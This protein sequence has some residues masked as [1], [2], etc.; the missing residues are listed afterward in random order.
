[1][2]GAGIMK[3]IHKIIAGNSN[4]MDN[5]P[6][7]S[8]DLV[9]TSPPYPMIKMWD[10]L[11][12]KLNPIIGEALEVGEGTRAYELMHRE[13]D[14]TWEEVDR[15]TRNG[16][17][18]AINIGDA[19]RRI[20]DDFR[21]YPNHARI[22]QFFEKAGY[23]VLPPII[24]RKESNKPTKFMGSGMLPPNAYVTLEHEYILLFRKQG[25]RRFN[26]AEKVKRRQSAYFWEERNSW[27]SDLWDL[28]GVSQRM[29]HVREK[30]AAYPF[31]L[32]Y[33]LVNMYS[34]QGDLVLDPFVG[35]G[36]TTVAAACSARNSIG[37]ELEPIFFD[38]IE[39]R[40][41]DIPRL[42][43][44]IIKE[45]IRKHI[46][47]IKNRGGKTTY[48]SLNYGFPVLS[49][50]EKDIIFYTPFNVIKKDEGEFECAYVTF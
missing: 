11:F 9:V 38:I 7:N 10:S 27:F 32:A 40:L 20:G 48:R 17:I 31:E 21:L 1:M 39:K 13:L 16:G 34:I 8:V 35:T 24:W 6:D 47:F 23:H 41:G 43:N 28:K 25:P 3:T 49:S 29:D 26:K 22:I 18:L 19:A 12:S 44:E 50:H 33:R 46:K 30:A 36:T 4:N 37:Y 2:I 14:K 42:A 45:R 15:V 5:I